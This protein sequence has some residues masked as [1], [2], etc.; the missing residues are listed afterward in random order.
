MILN[1]M[2]ISSINQK[3]SAQF[4]DR[5]VVAQLC[6]SH[7]K[8]LR[9]TTHFQLDDSTASTTS[10][11]TTTT[12]TSSANAKTS[13]TSSVELPTPSPDDLPP[14]AAVTSPAPSPT[15]KD[16]EPT[17]EDTTA[18][19]SQK[20]DDI[21]P[22][23]ADKAAK[24][25]DNDDDVDEVAAIKKNAAGGDA[26]AAATTP[27]AA[28]AVAAEV[29]CSWQLEPVII[30]VDADDDD[31]VGMKG[32]VANSDGLFGTSFYPATTTD[33]SVGQNTLTYKTYKTYEP[34][35]TKL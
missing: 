25:C 13:D 22:A 30:D 3:P 32:V 18:A 19:D 9:L 35:H 34:T 1:D 29:A 7:Y 28:A 8:T 24:D 2:I 15:G 23:I 33:A 16:G 6:R 20:V 21:G 4:V 10:T 17:E 5:V 12:T 31:V 14:T 11:T 27:S 26:F